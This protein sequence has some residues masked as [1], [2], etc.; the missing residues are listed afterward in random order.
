MVNDSVI[1]YDYEISESNDYYAELFIARKSGDSWTKERLDDD[2]NEMGAHVGNGVISE[3][4]QTLFY[5]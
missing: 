5:T 3:D 2:I 1:N 4:G